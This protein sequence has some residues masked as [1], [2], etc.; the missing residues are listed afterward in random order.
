VANLA[1]V[2]THTA[3]RGLLPSWRV[4][5]TIA[6]REP[7]SSQ[8]YSIEPFADPYYFSIEGLRPPGRRADRPD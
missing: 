8:T 2:G 6:R 5:R 7:V 3:P 4:S 1:A